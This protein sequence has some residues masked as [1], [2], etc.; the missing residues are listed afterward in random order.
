MITEPQQPFR[1]HQYHHSVGL[2]DGI[3]RQM[4]FIQSALKQ[5]GVT[6]SIFASQLQGISAPRAFKLNTEQMWD[7]DLILIHHSQGNRAL[8]N[9]SHIEIPKALIYHE[10][11]PPNFLQHDPLMAEL[12]YLGIKQLNSL[13][14]ET[15]ASFTDSEFNLEILKK[16]H[17]PHPQILPVMDVAQEL[18][19]PQAKKSKPQKG[20]PKNIL[21]VGRISPHH[22]QSLLVKIFYYL[23][24]ELPKNSKLILIGSQDPAYAEYVRLL[25][26]QLG[27]NQQVK[28]TGNVSQKILEQHYETADALLCVSEHQGFCI[29]LVEAMSKHVPIFFVPKTGVKETMGKSG[30]SLNTE[31]PFEIAEIVSSCLSNSKAVPAILKSQQERL[32]EL[33]GYQN[34]GKVQ[35][36]LVDL[37]GRIRTTPSL[38]MNR[39]GTSHFLNL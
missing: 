21:F 2:F 3:S 6:G 18:A 5:R 24:N 17:F 29:S 33:S 15:I 19:I 38:Q 22:N 16:H 25:S 28:I 10:I 34:A 23:K 14:K 12:S 37:I 39:R 1:I 9:L 27:L 30:V 7:C 4:F 8:E 20:S 31:N 11:I 13:R 32:N 36:I 35:N 26:E